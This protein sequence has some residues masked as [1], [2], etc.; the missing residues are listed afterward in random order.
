MPKKLPL[1]LPVRVLSIF[2]DGTRNASPKKGGEYDE[3][4][5][6]IGCCRCG[7]YRIHRN[8]YVY[9]LEHIALLSPTARSSIRI[10]P[11]RF[12]RAT[13]HTAGSPFL[14]GRELSQLVHIHLVNDAVGSLAVPYSYALR[15][16]DAVGDWRGCRVRKVACPHFSHSLTHKSRV[17]SPRSRLSRRVQDQTHHREPPR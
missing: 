9:R 2:A 10:S 4:Y 6:L 15:N 8:G 14:F 16:A 13:H 3:R 12:I 1:T 11:K 7:I 17:M 5:S